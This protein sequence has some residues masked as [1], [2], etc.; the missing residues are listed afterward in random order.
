M[1]MALGL[2]APTVASAQSAEA[3]S[4]KKL[5]RRKAKLATHRGWVTMT[6]SYRDV[7]NPAIR[8]KLLSGLPTVIASRTY[9]FP[10]KG[11]QPVALG[12]KTCRIVFDLWDEVFRIDLQQGGRGRQ[13][14]AVNV[15][16]VLRRCAE[17]RRQPI[18]AK[19][20]LK[21]QQR[22]FMGVAV[23]V[24]PLSPQMMD[25]I[26][27][28][29]SRPKGAGTVGPGDSLFGSFVGLFITHVPDADRAISFRTQPFVPAVLP[30][31][32]TKK[33]DRRAS[34]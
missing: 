11:K 16:G 14:V 28:W 6:V 10:D 33:G 8:R 4:K 30:V 20:S 3:L 1:A 24:N 12:V 32:P 23:E 19:R 31:I 7:V 26:K 21:P 5:S 18:V 22:Y 15:E 13:T 34:R 27:R 29:V 2:L 9:V 25:R 17:A